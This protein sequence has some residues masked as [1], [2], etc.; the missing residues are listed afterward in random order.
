MKSGSVHEFNEKLYKEKFSKNSEKYYKSHLKKF[1]KILEHV[2]KD[3]PK[4]LEIGCADGLLGRMLIEERGADVHGIDI[5]GTAVKVAITRGVKAKRINLEEKRLDFPANM[6]DFVICGD[7]IE[8]I[9]DTG[10]LLSDIRKVLKPGGHL[11][12]TVPNTASWYNRIFLL[13]GYLPTWIE[14]AS[15][16]YT[17]NPFM[18]ESCGHIRAFTKRSFIEL[19][20]L[21]GFGIQKVKGVS[22]DG[23]GTY[24]KRAETLWSGVDGLFSKS[25]SLASV[26][27]VKARKT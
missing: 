16:V 2:D 14:S 4:V 11:I 26:I 15:D 1:R 13:F 9:F 25:A 24:S 17:G 19:L 3:A 21:K 27:L 8:H 6:F 22:L 18:K 10:L 7:V 5:N 23:D 12:A 20:K